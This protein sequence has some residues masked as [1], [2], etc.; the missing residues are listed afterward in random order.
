MD[1]VSAVALTYAT[2]KE[3][4]R[5]EKV[6][7]NAVDFGLSI[8]DNELIQV[9]FKYQEFLINTLSEKIGDTQK[10]VE[11]FVYENEM[12]KRGF[13]VSIPNMPDKHVNSIMDLIDIVEYFREEKE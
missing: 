11:W 9:A 13:K 5:V 8:E 2:I 7:D 10:W 3:I 4:K 12:G 1:N 6:V